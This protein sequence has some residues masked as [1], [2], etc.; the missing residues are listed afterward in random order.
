MGT[1]ESPLPSA[2]AAIVYD[3]RTK[4]QELVKLGQPVRQG[5]LLKDVHRFTAVLEAGSRDVVL[6]MNQAS[7]TGNVQAMAHPANQRVAFNRQ[8]L[9]SA[10]SDV[11]QLATHAKFRLTQVNGDTAYHITNIRPG[12]LF[13]R[14]KLHNEDIVMAVNGQSNV[15]PDQLISLAQ[16]LAAKDDILLTVQRRGQEHTIAISLR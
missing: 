1:V 14:L 3:E 2:S 5:M 4:K 7:L 16:N 9:N 10:L 11:A 15:P 13:D 8:L 12:S 6:R